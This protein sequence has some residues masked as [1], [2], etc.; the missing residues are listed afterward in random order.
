MAGAS[1]VLD[2]EASQR[3]MRCWIRLWRYDDGA[4]IT[5]VWEKA[6]RKALGPKGWWQH[7][8]VRIGWRLEGGVVSPHSKLLVMRG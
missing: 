3:P 7:R 2:N 6:R 8:T 4:M 5:G 1:D